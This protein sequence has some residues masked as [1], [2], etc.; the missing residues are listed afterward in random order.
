MYENSHQ[1]LSLAVV[2]RMFEKKAGPRIKGNDCG[3]QEPK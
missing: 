3:L 1:E 2:E